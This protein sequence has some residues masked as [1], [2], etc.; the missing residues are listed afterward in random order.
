MNPAAAIIFFTVFLDLIGF[1]IV[2]PLLP[3]YAAQHQVSDVAV[4][5]LV[6]SF[7][8]MQFI[9]APIWGRWSDRVGRTSL[10][11]AWRSEHCS[12]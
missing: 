2:L 11:W 12:W 10:G 4:G 7:S 6:A 9:F 1:G 3:S 5:A 8:L